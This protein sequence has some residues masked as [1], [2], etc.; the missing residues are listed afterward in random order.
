MLA[1]G[2]RELF[3]LGEDYVG[4]VACK[5]MAR[6]RNLSW[7]SL[8]NAGHSQSMHAPSGHQRYS[9][10]QLELSKILCYKYE[11]YARG[12]NQYDAS[13]H[14]EEKTCAPEGYSAKEP[15][16]YAIQDLSIIGSLP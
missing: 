3:I 13:Y 8:G 1:A 11:S 2:L 12:R 15:L 10:G 4:M 5:D 7:K 16:R 14:Q 9:T 6:A